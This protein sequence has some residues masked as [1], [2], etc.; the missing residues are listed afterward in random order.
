MSLAGPRLDRPSAIGDEG[1]ARAAS[2]WLATLVIVALVGVAGV[3]LDQPSLVTTLALVVGMAVAGFGLLERDGT[4]FVQLFV[5]HALLVTFG[6]ATILLLVVAPFVT[7]EGL[8]VS[9][10]A[11][12]LLGIGAAWADVGSDGV[13]RSVEG[14]A[15]AYAAMLLAAIVLIAVVAVGV[16]GR[17]ALEL[18]V[19]ETAPLLSIGGFLLVLGGT[20]GTVLLGLRWLPILQLTRRDRRD[21]MER[22]LAALRR[23][24]LVVALGTPVVLVVLIGLGLGGTLAATPLS[25]PLVG[26]ALAAL[27]SWYVLGPAVAVAV[28]SLLAGLGAVL[29]RGLTRRFSADAT[30]RSAAITVGVAIALLAPIA[31]LPLIFRPVAAALVALT[32]GVGPIVFVVVVGGGVVAVWLG[33][34]P[35]RAG[36]P[37]IAAAGL[38]IAAIGLGRGH[39]ALVFACI[40]GAAIVWDVSTFGLG[41]TA[42][43][44]HVP[45]TRRLELF[46]GVLA[47]GVGVV[48]GLV[49]IG[50]E[51]LRSGAFAGVG[52]TGAAAVV[53]FGAIVLLLPVRG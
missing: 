52:S 5:G 26:P 43:L 53:V 31:I 35:D 36:G 17:W 24:L 6:S 2:L 18:L 23:T 27:S 38:V 15:L 13:K 49:A 33:L 39:P 28:G 34:L 25:G 44:G 48:A 10:F 46:H 45:E 1:R 37:A 8:A 11:L 50:L 19:G 32:I 40:A 41:V 14:T 12:A 4:G 3:V 9:G 30:R 20:A 42:E 16:L 51:T 21:A 29:L 47:I 22:R 7:R